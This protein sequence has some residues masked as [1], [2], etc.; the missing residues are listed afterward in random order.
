MNWRHYSVTKKL[1]ISMASL[2]VMIGLFLA[3]VL[4]ALSSTVS[5]FSALV[6][7][8]MQMIAQGN[9]AKI[10]LLKT[11]RNEKDA[12][13]NDDPLLIREA[14]A[15]LQEMRTRLDTVNGLAAQAGE[16]GLIALSDTLLK[17]VAQYQSLFVAAT[18]AP[19]G[20]QRL[21]AAIPMRKAATEAEKQ[22]DEL[23]VAVDARIG[24]VRSGVQDHAFT[25]GLVIL[26]MGAAAIGIALMTAFLLTASVA[27]PLNLLRGRMTA[28][29]EGDLAIEIPFTDRREDIGAMARAL[30]VFK[31]GLE[32][33]RRMAAEQA[34]AQAARERRAVTVDAL[35]RAFDSQSATVLRGVSA[36]ATELDATAQSMAAIAEQTNRQ[37]E[38]AA[39][40]A[41]RATANVQTVAT[42]AEEMA[43][44]IQEIAAQ[45]QR[46]KQIADKAAADVSQ[47]D[48]TVQG[49][50][51]SAQQIGAVLE[52]IQSIA[53]QTN[54]LALNATIEAARAGDAGKGFAVVA[55][56]VKSL[57]GQTAQATEAIASQ[58][59]SIQQVSDSVVSAV[60]SIGTVIQQVN[61]VSS[62]VAAAMEQQGASTQDISRNVTKAA[63]GTQ[64]VTEIV[65]QVT[66]AAGHTGGAASQVLGASRELAQQSEA[67]RRQVESFLADIRAA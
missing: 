50:A 1:A 14:T 30:A 32:Q 54:L 48:R 64:E 5:Q 51:T 39:T 67:L 28:L 42:A 17:S 21:L 61:E 65:Q 15:N 55:A 7:T 53:A 4:F 22:L 13:Y 26:G 52:L 25:V 16:A 9:V 19:V 66:E 59:T 31:Q 29:S 35:V 40:T 10:E 24:A 3:L 37:A 62:S 20:Q 6:D 63:Q 2:T 38:T 56:E 47:T 44:S 23:L 12:L 49:L 8:E 27:R 46:S 45:V 18:K 36:A 60:R 11:R 33:N 34:E 58:I 41:E 57:A 43:A